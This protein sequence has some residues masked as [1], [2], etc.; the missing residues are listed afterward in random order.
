ME[1]LL[2]INFEGG[3]RFTSNFMDSPMV[4]PSDQSLAN[5][6]EGSAPEPFD[7]MLA[8]MASCAAVYIQGYCERKGID[9]KQTRLRLRGEWDNKAR[10]YERIE[11]EI[12][13]AENMPAEHKKLIETAIH[14]SAVLR[15]IKHETQ[16][17]VAHA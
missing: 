1:N 6:G 13:G 11:F 4:I 10:V 5:G 9:W 14:R 2:E 3:R 8:G 12:D 16:I 7:L 15:Q 17:T